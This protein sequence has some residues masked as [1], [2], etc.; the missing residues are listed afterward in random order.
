MCKRLGAEAGA[1]LL[2]VLRREVGVIEAFT[3]ALLQDAAFTGAPENLTCRKTWPLCTPQSVYHLCQHPGADCISRAKSSP[4]HERALQL[5]AG[6]DSCQA[7]AT[8]RQIRS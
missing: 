8:A 3:S 5:F 6:R 7:Q 1:A 4:Q 2:V